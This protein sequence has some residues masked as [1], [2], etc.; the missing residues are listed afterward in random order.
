MTLRTLVIRETGKPASGETQRTTEQMI[1]A[2]W[3]LIA[4]EHIHAQGMNLVFRKDA[5]DEEPFLPLQP[6][7]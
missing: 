1:A 5:A 4:S 6:D 7:L 2:G 3:K